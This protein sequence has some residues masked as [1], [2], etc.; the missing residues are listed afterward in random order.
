MIPIK[1]LG[2]TKA[3]RIL[4]GAWA[5]FLATS[6]LFSRTV[7]AAEQNPTKSTT[8][9]PGDNGA[10][11]GNRHRVIV[12]TDIGGTDPDDFQSMVHLLLCADVLEIEGLI[13]SPYG[14]GRKR[15][16]LKVID[17]YANDYA[18]LKTYFNRYPSPELLKSIT[19]QGETE[20]A[21]LA[22]VRRS[23]VGSDWIVQ[24]ARRD[25]PRPLHVLVW[26]G[27]E[28]LAQ[29]LH[30]APDI[31]PKLQVYWIGGP[32][33]KWGPGAYQYLVTY[34]PSL[35]I[36]EANSTYRGW[37]VGGDQSGE[38]GNREFVEQHVA[39][40][41]VLGEFFNTQLGGTIKMGDSPSVGWLLRG[42]P[43]DPTKPG[44]G[45]SF[46][47]AW[48]RPYERFD[49]LTTKEDR[50]EIFGIL[51][52]AL[53]LGDN[54]P[55]NP[56]AWINVENQ[57]I[58]GEISDDGTIHFSFCPKAA[59]TYSFR[60]KSNVPALDGQTGAITSFYPPA[61]VTR[62]P[63]SALSDWWTDDQDPEL[64]EGEHRGA[65]TVSQWR[66]AFLTDFAKRMNRCEKPSAE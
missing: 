59:K 58:A 63:T 37:F 10:L 28:D 30:D 9:L 24:C 17:C 45:G 46:V 7:L 48:D 64:A 36:I 31:L 32:N 20:S 56:E 54:I 38:W 55:E 14:P 39:G 61:A 51:E 4:V 34:H 60:I 52:F 11:D 62:R 8:A 57:K 50:V 42:T 41:G 40:K 27:L 18:N 53:P 2:D 43:D 15:G 47:K 5:L 21:P 35:W 25:D 29:A 1:K 23:T 44:W 3:N 19:R 22:G 49:R 12:S 16:I 6:V 13:S 66:E 33:K 26:G 65:R